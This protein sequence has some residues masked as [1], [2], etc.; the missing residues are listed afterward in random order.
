MEMEPRFDPRTLLE[1]RGP[2]VEEVVDF[3]IKPGDINA[4]K[5]LFD[6]YGNTETEISAGYI[7][8]L[9]QEKD[10]WKPFTAEEIEEIYHRVS[11]H[12]GFSFNQLVDQGM[13]FSIVTGRYPVGGGW[14]V[15]REGKYHLTTTFVEA[16]FKS[17]PAKAQ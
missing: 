10:S 2:L 8:R 16:A 11:S 3:P 14:I 1:Q 6:A 4:N 5:R 17:S 15:L 13:S 7:I 9:C 12:E